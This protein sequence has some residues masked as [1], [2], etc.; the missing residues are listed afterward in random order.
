MVFH[1]K[2]EEDPIFYEI[3]MDFIPISENPNGLCVVKKLISFAKTVQMKKI[4]IHKMCCHL[5]QLIQNP[6]ANYSI[7]TAIDVIIKI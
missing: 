4:L 1:I 6:Y 5:I 7:Q 3:M 2:S